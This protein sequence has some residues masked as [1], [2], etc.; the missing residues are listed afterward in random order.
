ME[1]F[2]FLRLTWEAAKLHHYTFFREPSIP[3]SGS[4]V[5]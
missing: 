4:S 2:N 3:K 5:T 1:E